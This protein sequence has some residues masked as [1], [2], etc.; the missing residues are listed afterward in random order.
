MIV[1]N[2]FNLSRL[3]SQQVAPVCLV[4][5]SGGRNAFLKFFL[6]DQTGWPAL[7]GVTGR[8]RACG[9]SLFV[10]SASTKAQSSGQNGHDHDRP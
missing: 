5:E 10:L 4:R 9:H 8:S 3:L 6:T 2:S 1:F 7:F